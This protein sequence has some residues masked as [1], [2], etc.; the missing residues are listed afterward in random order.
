MYLNGAR[1]GVM[2]APGM[3]NADG[4]V[5][6]SLAGP[7]RWTVGVFGSMHTKECS[8]RIERKL[9]PPVPSVQEVAAAVAYNRECCR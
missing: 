4:E 2:M 8:V 6:G 1:L 9:P 7:L 5:V 3:K